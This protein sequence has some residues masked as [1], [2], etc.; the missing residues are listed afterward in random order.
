[1]RVQVDQVAST[2]SRETILVGN[3][4]GF[5]GV[6][7]ASAFSI[8]TG[9]NI[10]CPPYLLPIGRV[11]QGISMEPPPR[12]AGGAD[13][14]PVPWTSIWGIVIDPTDSQTLYAA[15]HHSGVY[16]STDGG[17]TW[18]PINEG[19]STRAVTAMAIS[20]D[21]QVLYAATEGEGVFRLGEIALDLIY[22]PVV[23]R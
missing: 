1:M 4:P 15:D 11:Q 12:R 23:L 10:V 20:S 3:P 21:G 5:R 17:A 6:A 8:N 7:L 16:L 2:Q 19:L 9:L 14:Y 22:L 13:Y 18:V